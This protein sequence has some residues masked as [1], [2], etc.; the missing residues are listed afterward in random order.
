MVITNPNVDPYTC[1][2]FGANTFKCRL[3]VSEVAEMGKWQYASPL[4]FDP[5]IKFENHPI[6]VSFEFFNLGIFPP[7]FVLLEL[8]CQVTLLGPK[9]QVFKNSPNRPFFGI[10]NETFSVIFKHRVNKSIDKRNMTFMWQF[11]KVQWPISMTEK[12]VFV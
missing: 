8:T 4:Q 12:L 3:K 1:G 2:N 9:F 11:C 7:I 5:W 6:N 10:F